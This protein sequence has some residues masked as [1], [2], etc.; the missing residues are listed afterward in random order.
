MSD[1]KTENVNEITKS[2]T[3]KT[4]RQRAH[5]FTQ[6]LNNIKSKINYYNKKLKDKPDN[7]EY[8]NRIDELEYERFILKLNDKD[9][10]T[11]KIFCNYNK[12]DFIK[13]TEKI[14]EF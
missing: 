5:P 12:I 4:I 6:R 8:K 7:A 1:L 13:M 10:K 2:E 3:T 14:R 11:L 9:I